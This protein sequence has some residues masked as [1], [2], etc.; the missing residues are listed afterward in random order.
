MT[1]IMQWFLFFLIPFSWIASN[2]P[3]ARAEVV[4]SNLVNDR[5][6]RLILSPNQTFWDDVTPTHGGRLS[7]L[8]TIV[9]Y[10]KIGPRPDRFLGTIYLRHLDNPNGGPLGS[11]I[12]TLQVDQPVE[13]DV[14]NRVTLVLD[15]LSNLGI[16]IPAQKFA[17]GISAYPWTFLYYGPATVGT[18][19]GDAWMGLETGEIHVPQLSLFRSMAV[20]LSV[21]PEPLSLTLALMV[22]LIFCAKRIVRR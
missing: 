3:A 1:T 14:D 13:L 15:G 11:P 4:F 5:H 12:A 10:D 7:E 6:G 18:T 2:G 19:T 20:E 8:R 21:V 17:L 9:Q 16:D 22:G